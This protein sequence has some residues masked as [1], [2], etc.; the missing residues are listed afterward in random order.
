[1]VATNI[2]SQNIL[3]VELE[4]KLRKLLRGAI[5]DRVFPGCVAGVV[6]RAGNRM[7]LAGGRR[8]FDDGAPRITESSVFD[9]A[10]ITKAIPT[11]TL[12]LKAVEEGRISLGSAISGW[13]PEFNN[14]HRDQVTLWHLLTQTLDHGYALSS[15]KGLSPDDLLHT[16]LTREF[17]SAPGD[18]FRYS[19][20][21]SVL[22][23]LLVERVYGMPL[24]RLADSMIFGPLRMDHTTFS[25]QDL[26]QKGIVPT[27]ID[28]WRGK[29]IRGEVH[30]ESAW[31]LRR[32][33]VPGS[34]G[35]FST[36]S[37]LLNFLEML[38]HD[39]VFEEKRILSHD[40]IETLQV[41]QLAA[42]GRWATLGWELNQLRFMGLRCSER[43]IGKTGFTGCLVM[44]DFERGRGLVFL[45]NHTFPRRSA[46]A[47]AINAVRRD[48]ADIVF[49]RA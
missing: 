46:G 34:A 20:A 7:L 1:M 47:D 23:G 18:V 21:T 12:A 9:I 16:V 48:V 22:L 42:M 28:D 27:E 40:T 10:S 25:P 14:N 44:C 33:M 15:C 3:A 19:N 37:D 45:S 8:T 5:E 35:L 39:G 2:S 43:T 17:R 38:L 41:N 26:D 49:A 6:S 30:D 36:A 13:V 32:I 4:P 31:V 29:V 24:D 11:A